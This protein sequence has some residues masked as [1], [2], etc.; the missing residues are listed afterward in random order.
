MIVLYNKV[1]IITQG[2]CYVIKSEADG[3]RM[4]LVRIKS[5]WTTSVVIEYHINFC[6]TR[7]SEWQRNKC[8]YTLFIRQNRH[9][10]PLVITTGSSSM[11]FQSVLRVWY[12]DSWLKFGQYSVLVTVTIQFI[13]SIWTTALPA[14]SGWIFQVAKPGN[15][16]GQSSW[17]IIVH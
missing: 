9:I 15:I 10:N 4:Y 14:W 12:F 8:R 11:N 5:T 1:R 6:S 13:Q 2:G 16:S 3:D 7:F 17:R